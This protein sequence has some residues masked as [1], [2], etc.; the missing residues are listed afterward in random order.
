MIAITVAVPVMIPVIIDT[1]VNNASHV[2][3]YTTSFDRRQK[4][5]SLHP[6]WNKNINH[7]GE[8]NRHRFD[9][10]E[11]CSAI[12]YYIR[13]LKSIALKNIVLDKACDI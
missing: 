4:K 8:Q 1:N 2:T 11:R 7:A 9:F 13:Q 10:F 3:I 12:L 5:K 6:A